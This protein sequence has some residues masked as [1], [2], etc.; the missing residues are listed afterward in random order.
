[1]PDRSLTR[2][3]PSGSRAGGAGR[4]TAWL[5]WRLG[6][7]LGAAAFVVCLAVCPSR[8]HAQEAGSAA[9]R[10]PEQEGEFSTDHSAVPAGAAAD[11]DSGVE[12]QADVSALVRDAA[13][14]W[15]IDPAYWLGVA[16]CESR[17][18]LDPSAYS[19]GSLHI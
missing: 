1:M 17:H 9:A 6:I 5:A 15:G 12:G 11:T 16:W 18:G 13:L 19:P 8:A 3:R 2:A 7:H 4:L 10:V 14:R